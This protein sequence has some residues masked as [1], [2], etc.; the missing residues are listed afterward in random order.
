MAK[1]FECLIIV[2][3]QN[4]FCPGGALAVPEGD[5]IVDPI[6]RIIQNFPFV[7]TTQDWHPPDHI[8]FQGHGGVWPPHCIQNT[9]GAQLHPKLCQDGIHL[10]ILKGQHPDRDAYS[11]FEET[12]LA[13]ELKKHA[14][15]K[16]FIVGL[17]TDYCVKH[18]A[19]DALRY[20]FQTV[21]F[22]DLVRSVDV[23]S[24]DGER[25]LKEIQGAG[26]ILMRAPDRL[27]F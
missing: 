21:V 4:D 9:W 1:P 8:S 10:R 18:T 16:V 2:D 25:A 3:L 26:G 22:T 15:K 5:R 27:V 14:V 24:G 17:A 20:G 11:G 13:E 19:L 7:V 12:P 23:K 6:N